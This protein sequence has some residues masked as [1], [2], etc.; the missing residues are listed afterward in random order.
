M[1]PTG[2]DVACKIHHHHAFHCVDRNRFKREMHSTTLVYYR[3]S[4]YNKLIK[5]HYC[6]IITDPPSA[7]DL[8][9]LIDGMAYA[10]NADANIAPGEHKFECVTGN[11]RP[12]SSVEWDFEGTTVMEDCHTTTESGSLT[13]YTSIIFARDLTTA[14]CGD[15]VTCTAT[16]EAVT[17]M[18]PSTSVTL[19]VNG[20][21]LPRKLWKIF[22]FRLFVGVF[23]LVL[24]CVC[25]FFCLLVLIFLTYFKLS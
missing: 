5:H 7:A 24:L 3:L 9:L 20:M 22:E 21:Y 14:D 8:Q 10:D 15:V 4:S 2:N 25:L 6:F 12:V 17:G 19:L 11:T 1:Y 16:N 18:D 13:S 23:M